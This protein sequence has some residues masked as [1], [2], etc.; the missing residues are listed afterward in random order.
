MQLNE[1]KYNSEKL[2]TLT[3]Q[4]LCFGHTRRVKKNVANPQIVCQ[5]EVKDKGIDQFIDRIFHMATAETLARF[6][7]LTS[8]PANQV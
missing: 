5:E 6:K 2:N 1:T 8:D 3:S 4:R 7:K